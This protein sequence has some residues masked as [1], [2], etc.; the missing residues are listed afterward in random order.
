MTG[1]RPH[2]RKTPNCWVPATNERQRCMGK[3]VFVRVENLH[4]VGFSEPGVIQQQ[5]RRRIEEI[6]Q[7]QS[8]ER[9][10]TSEI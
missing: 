10:I 4:Y 7:A 1:E 2:V 6:L 9:V 3:I 5:K 8:F